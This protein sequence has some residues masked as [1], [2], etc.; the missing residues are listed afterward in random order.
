MA[1]NEIVN[2]ITVKTNNSENTIKALKAEIAQL[3]KELDRATIGS[4]EFKKA[5]NELSAAQK[6]LKDALAQTKQTAG[7]MDGSYD[8]LVAT[9][10][11]LKKEWRA[12]A[13][14]VKRNNIGKQ[15]ND[16]N[17]QLKEL[18]SSIGNNQRKVGDY[19][20]G[21]VDAFSQLKAEIKQYKSELLT[22][23]EGTEEYNNTLTKL[24]DAQFK[25]KDINEKAALS[26]GDTGEVIKNVGK[27]A[28]G[29]VG[30]FNALQGVMTLVGSEGEA[31][32]ETMV[33][34]QAGIAIVQGLQG[35]EGL[36]DGFTGLKNSLGLA[37]VSLKGFI[38]KLGGLRGAIAKTGIGVLVIAIGALINKLL[39][40]KDEAEQREIELAERARQREEEELQALEEYRK[41]IISNGEELIVG[42]TKLRAEYLT[43]KSDYEKT[44]WI[45]KNTE[46]F[47]ALGLSVNTLAEAEDALIKNT[48]NIVNAYIKRA[49]VMTKQD[50][51]TQLAGKFIEQ[52]IKDEEAYEN[53]KNSS[54]SQKKAGDVVGTLNEQTVVGGYA[55]IAKSGKNKGKWVYT[56]EGI[57][58]L[59]E[60]V[61]QRSNNL[62]EQMNALA[63][64]LQ[65]QMGEMIETN[66]LA[67]GSIAKLQ[68]EINSL[69]EALDNAVVGSE[70]F[71]RINNEIV[72][73]EKELAEAMKQV[74]KYEQ[75][76]TTTPT[77]S[78][79][80]S[81]LITQIELIKEKIKLQKMGDYDAELYELDKKYEEEKNLF[82]ANGED[83]KQ[84]TE[85]YE[86]A[87]QEIKKRFEEEALKNIENE[88]NTWKTALLTTI[89]SIGVESDVDTSDEVDSYETG[90]ATAKQA[91]EIAIAVNQAKL[92]AEQEVYEER[93]AFLE[94]QKAFI[95]EQL[96]DEIL[97]AQQLMLLE[98]QMAENE[99]FWD[100]ATLQNAEKNAKAEELLEKR[101]L[102]IKQSVVRGTTQLLN[103]L[104]DALGENTAEGKAMAVSA[105]LINTFASATGAYLSAVKP[106]AFGPA[107]PKIGALFAAAALV[108]GFNQVRNILAV[109]PDGQTSMGN[110]SM[111][112]VS[113]GSSMPVQYTR[114]LMTDSELVTMNE[115]KEQKVIVLE[116]DIS[117]TQKK[118][119]VAE[120]N[121]S[122]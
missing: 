88:F 81:N 24:G 48:E 111:P 116:S 120:T 47:N 103:N 11:Q 40:L 117:D 98:Q 74:K 55:E 83:I 62:R 77:P 9:M 93:K 91:Y 35:I 94:E 75:K 12:T 46:A 102:N 68:D 53:F 89:D 64:E 104:S 80:T 33:K 41:K 10:A 4:D 122:F 23:E 52:R 2:V 121:S 36:A 54:A 34:L 56:E 71:V 57:K 73:K 78:G 3:K 76:T 105:A 87:K 5:S 69:K 106:P 21:I 67:D 1:Q 14:E 8:A 107:S 49:T 86:I 18:D 42:Y 59:E 43:L 30:G 58:N 28:G 16:I 6:Q 60:R 15:I 61:F 25:L 100:D 39:A 50:E 79:D 22:L 96:N 84:L 13:D 115:Q 63:D 92:L 37:N 45:D 26:V 19:T 32:N 44:E 29:V 20:G 114:E 113:V 66:T 90:D 65:E 31:L 38:T 118:V 7:A 82:I 109:N 17:N 95:E 99:M 112:N 119:E 72:A 51:L 110:T 108:Q 85:Y 70:N 101:K 97:K 27:F